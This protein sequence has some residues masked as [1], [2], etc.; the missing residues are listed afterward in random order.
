ME[1]GGEV[2]AMLKGEGRR[3]VPICGRKGGGNIC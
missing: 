1:E 2:G 3:V